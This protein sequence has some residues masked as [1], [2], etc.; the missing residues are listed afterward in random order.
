MY[1]FVSQKSGQFLFYSHVQVLVS[2][3]QK[4]KQTGSVES[5]SAFERLKEWPAIKEHVHE[6][7]RL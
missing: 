4:P 2:T 6:Y 5:F 1:Q 3:L 7:N